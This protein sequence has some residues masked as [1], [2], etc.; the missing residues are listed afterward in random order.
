MIDAAIFDIDGTLIDSVDAHARAWLI[1]FEEHGVAVKLDDVRLQIGKGAD[2]LLPHFLDKAA[3]D[4]VGNAIEARQ[5]EVFTARFL[6]Y[7]RPFPGVRTLFKR[8]RADGV[9]CVLCS[10]AK[11]EEVSRYQ[12]IAHISDLVDA[13]STSD[14]VEESKPAPD[15]VEA[16]LKKIAPTQPARCV[17]IG[18]TPYD[19]EAATRA[20]VS[21][22]GVL[23]GAFG[24]AE[25][26]AA[27]CCAVYSDIEALLANYSALAVA[28]SEARR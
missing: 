7:I 21:A 19:A 25:L 20:G 8:L 23:G 24:E 5:N 15:I 27:G 14:A 28:P 17:F 26:R 9:K 3:V 22:I 16:A 12:E 18:D 1:G 6:S 2:K 4:H 10:S 13:V 11:P